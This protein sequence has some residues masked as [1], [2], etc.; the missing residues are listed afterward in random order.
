MDKKRWNIT[1][2]V[3]VLLAFFTVLSY[4]LMMMRVANMHTVF[5][6]VLGFSILVVSYMALWTLG[7]VEKYAR[8]VKILKYCYL[9]CF[10]LG[11]ILFIILQILI[12]SGTQSEEADAD[13]IIVLGAGVYNGVPSMILVSRLNAAYDYMQ[14]NPGVPVIVT[15][16]LGRGEEKTDAEVMA[17]YLISRG[18][19]ESLIWIEDKSTNTREN[20]I[21]SIDIMTAKGLDVSN[22]KVAVISNEFH[23]YRAGIIAE[24]VGL[25]ALTVAAETPG[26]FRRVLCHFREA[27]SLTLE[28]FI[29]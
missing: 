1:I 24:K 7:T 27:I 4:I 28:F 3:T 17:R 5:Y 16:G 25:D 18:I 15:G 9:V 22:I 6:L 20:F 11:I 12:F 21:F 19:D 26:F 8:T 14:L 23:L 29:N 10:I 13:V 2:I